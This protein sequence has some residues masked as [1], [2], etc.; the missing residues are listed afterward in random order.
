MGPIAG[1]EEGATKHLQLAKKCCSAPSCPH[2]GAVH[3]LSASHLPF[4]SFSISFSQRRLLMLGS[5]CCLCTAGCLLLLSC[6]QGRVAASFIRYLVHLWVVPAL[7]V[8]VL[9]H[10]IISGCHLEAVPRLLLVLANVC[11]ALLLSSRRS[12]SGSDG[13]TT[14]AVPWPDPSSTC[15]RMERAIHI[16][17]TAPEKAEHPWS[18]LAGAVQLLC[19]QLTKPLFGFGAWT[20]LSGESWHGD[21]CFQAAPLALLLPLVTLKNTS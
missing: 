14:L 11:P 15:Q 17:L 19:G 10:G 8:T 4:W 3:V 7:D 5:G 9:P 6:P 12:S 16:A 18:P 13:S 2:R 1:G 20:E 21:R